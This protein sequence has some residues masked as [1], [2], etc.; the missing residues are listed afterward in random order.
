MNFLAI[1]FIFATVCSSAL[2]VTLQGKNY[3]SFVEYEKKFNLNFKNDDEREYR[4]TVFKNN[5]QEIDRLNA[6][7][8]EMTFGITGLTHLTTEEFSKRLVPKNFL[9]P[10]GPDPIPQKFS[11]KAGTYVDWRQSNVVSSIKNQKDCGDCYAFATAAAVESYTAIKTRVLLDLSEQQILDCDTQS[12]GC[13]AGYL[14]TPLDMAK[15]I[16]LVTDSSY[17]YQDI[18]QT[19]Q[20]LN[21]PKYSISGHTWLDPDEDVIADAVYNNGPVPFIMISPKSLQH[22]KKGIFSMTTDECAA[23]SDGKN[24]IPV[25]VGYSSDYWIIKNSWGPEWGEKGYFRLKKGI[26]AC[27]MTMEARSLF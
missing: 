20:S 16:G 7:Y 10:G 23:E 14:S 5:L 12:F 25:I 4:F 1:V 18:Q 24:H 13:T 3:A 6:K 21:G 11:T 27:N 9:S 17:P 15:D 2:A 22:Y 19:C 26:N 8:P